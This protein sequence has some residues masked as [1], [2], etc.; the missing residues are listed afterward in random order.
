MTLYVGLTIW[1]FVLLSIGLRPDSIDAVECWPVLPEDKEKRMNQYIV[2]ILA[3]LSFALMWF[4]TA[5]RSSSIG[6]DTKNYLWYFGIFT[7]GLDRTSRIEVGYQIFNYLLGKITHDEHSFLIIMAS[8][9]YGGI[10]IYFHKHCKNLAV[11]LCLFF[12]FFFSIYTNILRQGIAMIIALYGYQL[13][14]NGKKIPAAVVFL[15]ATTFHTTAFLCFLLY[16]NLDNLKKQWVVLSLT[17]LCAIISLT[18][19]LKMVVNAVVPKYTSYFY[20]QYASSGWLAITFSLFTYVVF[21]LLI[22]KSLDENNKADN[23]VATNF[24]LL[25]MLTAFG[26]AVNLFERAGEYFMLIAITEL[27]NILYRGKVKNFR[28]WLF[29]IG[30]FYLLFFILSLVYRP[31]WNHLYPYEFWH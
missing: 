23:I 7:N 6:N 14:K 30:T 13:L 27:P 24:T 25:L 12:C 29:G 18:G 22:S 31:G 20:G 15:L 26:Y 10:G 2:S 16:L 8:I 4:L 5:F 9:M 3:F 1:F 28:L 17:G 21:Y 19:V 11:S